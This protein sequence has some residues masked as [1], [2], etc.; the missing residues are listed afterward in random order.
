MSSADEASQLKTLVTTTTPT[1]LVISTTCRSSFYLPSDF[2][3]FACEYLWLENLFQLRLTPLTTTTARMTSATTKT[4]T[5]CWFNELDT[6]YQ[7]L[8]Q[9]H[10][11]RRVAVSF[12]SRSQSS[13]RGQPL[14]ADDG[15]RWRLVF[16]S[17][18]DFTRDLVLGSHRQPYPGMGRMTINKGN[19]S[20]LDSRVNS[21][22]CDSVF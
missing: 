5:T 4:T 7:L 11:T 12:K 17:S 9:A 18:L 8:C 3:Y 6:Y 20:L 19:F 2:E 22:Y 15:C 14:A 13:A 10:Q 1:T 21:P 16:L